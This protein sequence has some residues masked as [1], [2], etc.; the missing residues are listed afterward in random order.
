MRASLR[1]PRG[2]TLVEAIIAMTIVLILS[3]VI[4]QMIYRQ[5]RYA[6]LHS[7]REEGQ[8]NARGV[9]ELLTSEIR[10]VSGDSGIV[11]AGTDTLAIRVPGPWGRI[12]GLTGSTLD[13]AFPLGVWNAMGTYYPTPVSIALTPDSAIPGV[14]PILVTNVGYNTSTAAGTMCASMSNSAYATYYADSVAVVRFN[15]G[16]GFTGHT[17]R[18]MV[19]PYRVYAYGDGDAVSTTSM[20]DR[21]M[22]RGE[23]GVGGSR[24]PLAGPIESLEF[25]YLNAS[26]NVI[27]APGAAASAVRAVR[28]VLTTRAR[29]TVSHSSDTRLM[30]R[31]VDSTT[32]YVRN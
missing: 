29:K 2:F 17:N 3:T 7:A 31:Q 19:Y 1:N 22:Y 21:W 25:R 24:Q 11:Y 12:C 5:S 15:V 30:E 10:T 16:G 28:V 9:L 4:F 6:E 18:T 8:E 14:P 32:I 27:A 20:S 26:G 13:V 23:V